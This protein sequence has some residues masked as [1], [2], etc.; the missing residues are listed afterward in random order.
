MSIQSSINSMIGSASRAVFMTKHLAGQKAG[1]QPASQPSDNRVPAQSV[2][3][4]A[5]QVA[6]QHRDDAIQAKK[7]QQK[8]VP[9]YGAKGEIING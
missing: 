5:A 6:L 2:Q 8:R 3:S 7:D 9:I 4:Q 1:N